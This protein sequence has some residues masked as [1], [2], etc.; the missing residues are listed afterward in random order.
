MLQTVFFQQVLLS[1]SNVS[2][3]SICI[4]SRF[5]SAILSVCEP[6]EYSSAT[7]KLT[8]IVSDGILLLSSD[9]LCS[10]LT[11]FCRYRKVVSNVC[12]GGVD[13]QQNLAQHMCPL[14]A[15]KGLQISI[16][17]ESL[18]VKPGEDITFIVR[19]EQ[20]VMN[21]CFMKVSS[22]F[23]WF[24]SLLPVLLLNEIKLCLKQRQM[25]L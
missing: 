7:I 14:T 17:E 21:I 18:A 16:R 9:S 5:W 25:S 19:Q 13:L 23:L 20:V 1:K 4:I 8:F 12:E 3:Q 11:G 24:L 15:P 10:L 2:H 6:K 22:L